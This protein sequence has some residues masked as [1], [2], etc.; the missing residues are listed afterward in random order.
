[1]AVSPHTKQHSQRNVPLGI[2][3]LARFHT[4]EAWLCWYPAVWGACVAA[5]TQNVSLDLYTFGRIL[6]GIWSSVTATHAAFCTFNDICDRNLDA[7]VLRC[8]TR[9]LPAGMLT[10]Q[11]AIA[12]F[13]AWIPLTLYITRL[14]LGDAAA[15]A[16]IPV[17]VLSFVYPFMKRLIPFPQVV[18]GAVIGGAVFPGWAAV[19]GQQLL[20]GE[21]SDAM[22]LFWATFFW[23]IYFDVIYATQDSPD[24]AKI[25]VKSL[26]VL[27]GR[28]VKFFLASLGGLQVGLFALAGMRAQ[29]SLV[30]WVLG[31]GVWT[32]SIPW[33]LISLDLKDRHSGGRVF[34]ANIKLGLYLTGITLVELA[35][36]RVEF[37]SSFKVPGAEQVAHARPSSVTAQYDPAVIQAMGNASRPPVG[38]PTFTCRALDIAFSGSNVVTLPNNTLGTYELLTEVNYSETCWLAPAC[39]VNPRSANETA[40]IIKIISSVQTKFAVRSGGHKS[41]P[42]FASI[43]GSGILIS[44]ANLTTLTLSDDRS[45]VVVGTG[46]RWQAVYDFL[47]PQGLTAVGGRVGMVGVGGFLLGGGVS[48][49]TNERG[50]GIDNIKSFEVVLADGR[51]VTA[52]PTQNKDLYRGLRGG[53]SNFGIV[54]AFELYAHPLGTITFEARAYSVNQSVAAIR[55]LADYQLSPTGQ[56]ADPYSRIDLTITKS[57]VNVLLLHTKPVAS[58]V[59]AFQPIYKLSPF[60]PL[61]PATNASLSTLLFL[62]KQ[63][64]PNEHIRVQ[65]GTFTHTVDANF[66]VQ[67]YNIFLA[68]TANL[69]TGATATWVPVAIPATVASF[70]ALNGGNL[71]G[72]SA[73]PQ[74]WYEWYVNWKNPADDAAVAAVVKS[75][76]QKLDKA[77][78]QKGV[79]LPYLFMNVAG[80]EQNVLASFGRRNLEEIKA[81]AKKYD[82]SGVFQRL[83][84]DGYLIRDA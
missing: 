7:H 23:V 56:R 11:E 26:A 70:A 65:G 59:P 71:L 54:T 51:I 58:P 74:V 18:L 5:A 19:T 66:M 2:W 76:R 46:N 82:Y 38:N 47:T 52:S 69:P 36:T 68:E 49:M 75:V 10:V 67:A 6:F 9:P 43:D 31:L 21:L 40:R 53:S 50:L 55:A 16:F 84:N 4:R 45:S 77:A 81:V 30:F 25:G 27:L 64:F 12:T 17:W 14:T 57:A 39:I 62:S 15:A 13:I 83:Q 48:F 24:D 61:A 29:L 42:G 8:K 41:A 79:L 44:L 28:N 3:R 20:Q 72:L 1:M 78:R 32:L 34:M 63:A 60:T 73:V 22:P 33:H 35:L 80:R 37:M